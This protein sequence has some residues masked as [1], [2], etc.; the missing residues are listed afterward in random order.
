MEEKDE[1]ALKNTILNLSERIKTLEGLVQRMGDLL[2]KVTDENCYVP[3]K[4]RGRPGL[5]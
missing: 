1:A 4:E 5:V 3:P 2:A